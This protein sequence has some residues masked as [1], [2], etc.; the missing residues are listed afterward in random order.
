VKYKHGGTSRLVKGVLEQVG[1]FDTATGHFTQP[2][3]EAFFRE[4]IVCHFLGTMQGLYATQGEN[5][6]G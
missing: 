4:M 3:D 1:L 6:Y 2:A 5:G